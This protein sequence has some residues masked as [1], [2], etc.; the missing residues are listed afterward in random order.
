MFIPTMQ[1]APL[2]RVVVSGVSE[3]RPEHVLSSDPEAWFET[4]ESSD[5]LPW[6]QVVLPS[7]M[8]VVHFSRCVLGGGVRAVGDGGGR[9]GYVVGSSVFKVQIGG[10]PQTKGYVEDSRSPLYLA[11]KYPNPPPPTCTHPPGTCPSPPPCRYTY[12]HGHRRS[13]YFR[14]R[15]WQTLTAPDEGG[16]FSKINAR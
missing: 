10:A 14:L 12:R 4:D 6:I 3:G 7:N 1:V 9:T 2:C 16:P 15:N 11:H 8:R 5:P 13:G